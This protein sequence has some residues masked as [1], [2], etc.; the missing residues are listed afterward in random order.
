MVISLRELERLVQ[1]KKRDVMK[2]ALMLKPSHGVSR[3]SLKEAVRL[4]VLASESS[5]LLLEIVKWTSDTR[6]LRL[7]Y[8]GRNE[9]R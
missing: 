4:A 5:K 2:T 8:V 6:I 1:R 7:R 9:R 3:R